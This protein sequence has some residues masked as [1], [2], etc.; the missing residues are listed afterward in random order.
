MNRSFGLSIAAAIFAFTT[1]ATGT[2]A[3][4]RPCLAKVEAAKIAKG[5]AIHYRQVHGTQCWYVGSGADKSE[6][7]PPVRST[8]TPE[9]RIRWLCGDF[10]PSE[11]KQ[12]WPR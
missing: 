4:A 6:F 5:E 12:R 8:Y 1:L 3:H 10:C 11:F 9:E 7:D 2:S